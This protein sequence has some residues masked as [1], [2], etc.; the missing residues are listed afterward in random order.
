MAEKTE[1]A[2]DDG[3]APP[4]RRS[5]GRGLAVLALFIGLAALAGVAYLYVTLVMLGSEDSERIAVLES[6]NAGVAAQLRRLDQNQQ[7]AIDELRVSRETAF[8]TFRTEQDRRR[9]AAEEALAVSLQ[10]VAARNAEAPTQAPQSGWQLAETE[11]LLRIANRQLLVDKDFR[12]ALGLLRSADDLLR[13]LDDFTLYE[14]RATLAEE[15]R[16]LEQAAPVN[17]SEIYLRLDTTKR[18]LSSL[19]LALPKL[20]METAV[21][22]AEQSTS[23]AK[24][25]G[26]HAAAPQDAQPMRAEEDVPGNMEQPQAPA[27]RQPPVDEAAG[28]LDQL[29]NELGGLL[30]LRR[31]DTGFKPPRAP[32]EAAYL[33]LNLR[34]ML[35]QAQLSA[36]RGDQHVYAAS[37]DQALEWAKTYLDQQV[38]QAQETIATL[39]VLRD[40]RLDTPVPDISGSLMQLRELRQHT[41]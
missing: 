19:S 33:E 34:L 25:N 17:I 14:V 36:L 10:R 26:A 38:P 12:I 20:T 4:K 15:I 5:G 27:N 2:K 39:R 35:E 37:L 18:Q 6:A 41:Q 9:R 40:L 16:S 7:T 31:I 22:T 23:R 1:S 32:T 13:D 28:W 3:A 30:R 24:S 21:V 11:Y 29:T 8:A